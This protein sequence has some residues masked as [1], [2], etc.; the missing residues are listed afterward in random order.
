[1]LTQSLLFTVSKYTANQDFLELA[2]VIQMTH[3]YL[4]VTINENA[5]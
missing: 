5:H 2:T 4:V 1:M 3:K